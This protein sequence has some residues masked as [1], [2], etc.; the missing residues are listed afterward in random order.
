VPAEQDN[1]TTD[2]RTGTGQKG[3][4]EGHASACPRR[5]EARPSAALGGASN[6]IVQSSAGVRLARGQR[7]EVRNTCSARV[8]NT[9][10]ASGSVEA[11]ARREAR[12]VPRGLTHFGCASVISFWRPFRAAED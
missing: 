8:P 6:R 3:S 7:S 2:H 4:L 11:T 9:T 12:M 1:K 5:A 10:H